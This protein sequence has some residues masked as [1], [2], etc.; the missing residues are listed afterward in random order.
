MFIVCV[1]VGKNVTLLQQ[2]YV[3]KLDFPSAL[4]GI[5]YPF[6]YL[7]DKMFGII[8]QL[9]IFSAFLMTNIGKSLRFLLCLRDSVIDLFSDTFT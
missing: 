9:A 1:T 2:T 7:F 8:D 3:V 6:K 5:K 4:K